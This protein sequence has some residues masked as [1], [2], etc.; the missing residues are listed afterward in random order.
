MKTTNKILK[1]YWAILAALAVQLVFLTTLA[2]SVLEID[3]GELATVQILFG[4]AH[5]TGYPLFTVLGYLFSLI[6]LPVSGIVQVNLLASIF[7]S[8][9]IFF[10]IKATYICFSIIELAQNKEKKISSKKNKR[11]NVD[12]EFVYNDFQ[13][14]IFSILS[15][16]I[17]AFSTTF[18]LQ[19]TS[20][21]VY[22]LHLLLLAIIIYQLLVLYQTDDNVNQY[23]YT[24]AIV[25]GLGFA[26]HMS[27]MMLIPGAVL[28]VFMLQRRSRINSVQLFKSAFLFVLVIIGMYSIIL[29]RAAYDPVLNWGNTEN[30]ENL[31]RHISG[32]QYQV[33]LFSSLQVAKENFLNF[34]QSLN[35][36]FTIP[37]ILIALIGTVYLLKH[38]R[39]IFSFFTI[40]FLFTTIYAS[41]YDIKDLQ[42]YYL[43]AI[44]CI[45]FFTFFGILQIVEFLKKFK[46]SALIS[47]FL[48]AFI[49]LHLAYSNFKK[50]DQSDVFIFED[51]TKSLIKSTETNA[52]IFSYQWDY[53]LSASYYFQYVEGFRNDVLII[54][55]ELLRRS[56]YY[57][58]L[59]N[60]S[61]NIFNG[62]NEDVNSFLVALKPFETNKKFDANKL[63]HYFQKIMTSLIEY[64][65]DDHPYYLGPEIV[66]NELR[67]NQFSLPPGYNIV[68]DLFLFKVVNTNEYVPA[69]DPDYNIRRPK[70]PNQYHKFI[71]SLCAK[72]LVY[73]TMYEIQ[74]N[75]IDRAKVYVKKILDDFPETKL[76]DV[77][78]KKLLL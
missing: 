31:F 13:K 16:L 35:T 51:Y 69:A 54:D 71:E 36:E 12:S 60:I 33:W 66:E 5:P 77:I 22:S 46:K 38:D 53:F 67:N 28:I 21:E 76:P 73:R 23:L 43:L 10:I 11:K 41:N 34:F 20:V 39:I 1:R 9:S 50:V 61:P 65:F 37:I 75:K 42:T 7:C 56:W 3:S 72:M 78:K 40:S 48:I 26:N 59:E 2:P 57:E 49:V 62:F 44:I 17:L 63:E 45:S 14:K 24:V 70:N 30:F 25:F 4:V 8:V 64:N 52:I 55:K 19:S 27:T 6:P 68:P 74:Y 32:K 47:I 29:I 15:S 58:Q 18:W